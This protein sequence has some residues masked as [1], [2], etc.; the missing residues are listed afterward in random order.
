MFL[1]IALFV[2]FILNGD[3]ADLNNWIEIGLW[4]AS[5]AGLLSIRKW[6]AAFAI[7]TL[8]Y[9]TST[10]V[11]ILIYAP[12]FFY[13]LWPNALRIVIN[14]VVLVYL[15]RSIFANRFK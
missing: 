2:L 1:N 3:Y 12:E 6:G 10:S 5:I 15:F 8:S 7:F 14:V 9:S 4:L 11:G 13:Q